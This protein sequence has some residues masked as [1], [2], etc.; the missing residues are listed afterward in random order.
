MGEKCCTDGPVCEFYAKAEESRENCTDLHS[1]FYARLK[2]A[3]IG[4]NGFAKGIYFSN[5]IPA[6][7]GLG[8]TL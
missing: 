4:K 7:Q 8:N 3:L 5:R 2:F 1:G 6:A